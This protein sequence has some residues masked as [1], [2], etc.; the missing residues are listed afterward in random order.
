[1]SPFFKTNKQKNIS[2]VSNFLPPLVLNLRTEKQAG[3]ALDGGSI[4]GDSGI[5]Y[6]PAFLMHPSQ[7]VVLDQDDHSYIVCVGCFSHRDLF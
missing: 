2:F 5:H 1:M 3:L 6:C 7:N 4:G